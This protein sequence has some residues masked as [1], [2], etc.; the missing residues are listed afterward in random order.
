MV[1]FGLFGHFSTSWPL[2]WPFLYLPFLAGQEVGRFFP[3]RSLFQAS[4]FYAGTLPLMS[5]PI[6][7]DTPPGRATFTGI[8]PKG[9]VFNVRVDT[10]FQAVGAKKKVYRRKPNGI[11]R[12][13]PFGAK[14]P[15][16]HKRPAPAPAQSAG[17]GAGRQGHGRSAI[18]GR[19]TFGIVR[20]VHHRL[21]P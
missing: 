11:M 19:G 16:P 3:Y 18:I 10:N 14:R 15:K 4:G 9:N 8:N 21:E 5:C 7:C 20:L 12:E 13:A 6:C 17:A 2:L 1:A